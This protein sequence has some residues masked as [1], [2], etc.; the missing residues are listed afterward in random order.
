LP[1]DVPAEMLAAD[2]VSDPLRCWPGV[3]ERWASSLLM[4]FMATSPLLII[5]VAQAG[6]SSPAP[7][8][9]VG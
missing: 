5:Y 2:A 8:D 6:R 7:F 1:T 9:R 3:V 4:S